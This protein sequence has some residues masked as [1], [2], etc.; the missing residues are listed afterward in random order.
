M[1]CYTSPPIDRGLGG[2]DCRAVL[3]LSK[4]VFFLFRPRSSCTGETSLSAPWGMRLSLHHLSKQA[5]GPSALQGPASAFSR[6][7][8]QASGKGGGAV[9]V[10][11][12]LPWQRTQLPSLSGSRHP[13]RRHQGQVFIS[14]PRGASETGSELQGSGCGNEQGR[15]CRT[16]LVNDPGG[17]RPKFEGIYHVKD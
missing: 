11:A 14:W 5:Q 13:W 10:V 8:S 9:R 16:M 15:R 6:G 4:P 12:C 3:P 1:G 7:A 2:L 17:F